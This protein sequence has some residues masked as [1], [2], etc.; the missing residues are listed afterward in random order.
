MWQRISLSFSE[1]VKTGAPKGLA[2][3]STPQ[4][5]FSVN[6]FAHTKPGIRKVV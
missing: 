1:E 4:E 3:Y 6:A 2:H 5:H